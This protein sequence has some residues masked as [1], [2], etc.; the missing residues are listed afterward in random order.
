MNAVQEHLPPG[1]VPVVLAVFNQKG[2]IGKTTTSVNLAACLAALGR[3][4]CVIDLDSQGNATTSLGVSPPPA[5][6]AYDVMVGRVSM[7]SAVRPTRIPGVT[8]CAAS[9]DLA[10]VD[11]ELAA[12]PNRPQMTLRRRIEADPPRA[13]FILIDCPPAL[14]MLPV[15][16]LAAADG[17]VLPVSPQPLAHDGLHKAWH[18]VGVIRNHLNPRLVVEGILITF[19]D[20]SPEALVQAETIRR[21][22][23]FRVFSTIIPQDPS[24]VA[25]SG[26]DIP[27]A[28]YEPDGVVANCY[29]NLAGELL[30]RTRALRLERLPAGLPSTPTTAASEAEGGEV[31][32]L[33]ALAKGFALAQA[34]LEAAKRHLR[35]WRTTLGI[36][37]ETPTLS[38][39][40]S[41]TPWTDEPRPT[42]SDPVMRWL[43]YITA[44]VVGLA[45][46]YAAGAYPQLM[47]MMNAMH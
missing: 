35:T 19:G 15:N 42:G 30:E 41:L 21:E 2:G 25:A 29:L 28:V 44:F 8:I 9:D 14:G 47:A 27:V 13:D 11:I 20:E 26:K 40:P 5:I 22:F 16:A 3:T 10:A 34:D 45:A 38:R 37:A 39:P 6:G 36:T 4:V 12:D 32:G 33:P 43:R 24:V 17:V 1:N 23:G 7:A 18:H 31:A 46:G